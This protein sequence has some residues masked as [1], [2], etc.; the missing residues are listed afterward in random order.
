LYLNYLTVNPP[1]NNDNGIELFWQIFNAER[2]ATPVIIERRKTGT[3]EAFAGVASVN[4]T[5]V[6]YLQTPINTDSFAY[7]YRIRGTDLCGEPFYSRI[8]TNVLLTG[9]KVGAY[10][11]SM[12]FMPY[13]GWGN[14]AI[15]Y[16]IY[17]YL[18][19]STAYVL[20]EP[21]VNSFSA[22][23][24]NGQEYYT[25]CYRVKATKVGT[26]T[27]SWSNDIC[28]NFEPILYIPNA[29][30]PNDDDLNDQFIL[31]GGALKTIDFKIF[32]RWGELLFQSDNLKTFWN[33]KYKDKLQP[34]GVYMYSCTYTDFR[35]KLYSTKG[36]ITLL[37]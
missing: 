3:T 7:D 37:K 11:V 36:T 21:N 32:N 17:R 13:L 19:E 31:S 8:H 30:T 12:N 28:F 16:D 27:V 35:G 33:G 1:P 20:Y 6:N 15:T 9:S 18:P 26:D 5:E 4:K 22:Y 34:Q 10:E 14:A 25:Q 29:F 2:H 23:Y 24:N